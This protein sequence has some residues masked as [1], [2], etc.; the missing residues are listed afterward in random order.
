MKARLRSVAAA[1]A[2]G[3]AVGLAFAPGAAQAE[4]VLRIV[5]H[6][7][8][9]NLDPIWTTA[10]ITRNHGYMVYDTLFAVDENLEVRPQMVDTWS[11]SDDGLVYTFTL[12]DGLAWHDGDPVTAADC[13]ASIERW[14]KRDGMGQKL[15]QFT[16]ALAAVDDRTFTLTL[17]EPYGLVLASLGKISSNTPFMMKKEHAEVDAFKQVPE[18]VGSGPFKFAKD[19][20]VP[21]SPTGPPRR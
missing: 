15:L 20:W 13:V 7:D 4:K 14:G 19:L 2:L 1:L 12:R 17:N 8:L 11:V 18:V 21:G 5:P 10:Y 6:A 3:A 16:K 9:K